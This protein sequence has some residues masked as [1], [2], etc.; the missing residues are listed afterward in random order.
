MATVYLLQKKGLVWFV[1]VTERCFFCSCC[2]L[3]TCLCYESVGVSLP[4]FH[5][6]TRMHTCVYIYI[7]LC[8]SVCVCV[9]VKRQPR[10]HSVCIS[11]ATSHRFVLL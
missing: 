6:D 3:V 1:E 10:Y 8:F 5:K 11:I 2:F 4:A 9:C 7:C